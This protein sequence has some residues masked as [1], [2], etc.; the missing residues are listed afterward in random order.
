MTP[1]GFATRRGP[2]LAALLAGATSAPGL[3]LP[4]LSDDWAHIAD[5]AERPTLRTPFGYVRPLCMATYWLDR[6]IGGLSPWVFH[7]TNLVLIAAAA[8]LVVILIRRLSGDARLAG[9]AGILF[10]LHPYHV[11]N[12]AWIAA[13]ADPLYTLLFLAAVWSYDSWRTAPAGVP[14]TALLLFEGAMLAKETAVVLPPCLLLLG[15]CTG[16]R[17]VARAEWL[18]G[19]L[20]LAGIACVHFLVLRPSVLGAVDIRIL[21]NFG[22]SWIKNLLA[23]G[24][25]A[26]LPAHT[27]SFEAR[28]ALWGTLAVLA[29]GGLAIMARRHAGRLPPSAWAAVPMFAVLLGLSLVSFQERYL[30]LPGAASALALA[31]LLDAAPRRG[32]IVALVLLLSGWTG[33]AWGHWAGWFDA[34]RASTRLIGDLT[35][36]SARP[37]VGEIVVANMPHRVHGAPVA[38]DFAAAVA[39]SGGRPVVVRTATAV[40]FPGPEVDGLDGPADSAIRRP[41]PVAEVRLR[42]DAGPFSRLVR[43]KRPV[44]TDRVEWDW[45]SVQF[46]GAIR[47]RVVIPPSADPVRA[48]YVWRDGG[49]QPLF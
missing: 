49:L 11:E 22:T 5:V 24:A 44:N 48:A 15:L 1:P 21:D 34:G 27:E 42:V 17:R 6:R 39:L 31:A 23:F 18:R 3:A 10:A 19:Y 30:F 28:P 2:L 7:L 16:S 47:V 32:R 40:D 35:R 43:P 37:G 26:I 29:T 13:R 8:A 9:L 41:P 4:F 36:A 45:A 14:F 25:A 33:S 46:D 38:A 20:P 12:A